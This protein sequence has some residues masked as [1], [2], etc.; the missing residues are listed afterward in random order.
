MLLQGATLLH[1]QTRPQV[2]GGPQC[3]KLFKFVFCSF[4]I[5]NMF[6]TIYKVMFLVKVGKLFGIPQTR[7]PC[8]SPVKIKEPK[9]N[10]ENQLKHSSSEMN[11]NL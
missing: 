2:Y 10:I 5:F 3:S 6:I 7:K 8:T 11:F 1:M 4:Y 9:K